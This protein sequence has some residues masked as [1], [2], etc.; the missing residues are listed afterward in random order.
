MLPIGEDGSPILLADVQCTGEES[1]LADC[2]SEGESYA[3]IRC[4]H[5]EDVRVVC[6][7]EDTPPGKAEYF[8]QTNRKLATIHTAFFF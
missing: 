5:V 3:M 1:K 7:P 2:P 8:V 4:N 6:I